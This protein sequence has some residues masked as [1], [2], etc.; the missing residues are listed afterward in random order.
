M[1]EVPKQF[2][3]YEPYRRFYGTLQQIVQLCPS[4]SVQ[5]LYYRCRWRVSFKS[6]TS[7]TLREGISGDA[8]YA[9]LNGDHVVDSNEQMCDRLC[10][11]PGICIR[12][13]Y[14]FQLENFD[15]S[16]QWVG[17]ER[18]QNVRNRIPYP[19]YQ[20]RKRGLLTYFYDGCWTGGEPIGCC[21]SACIGNFGKLEFEPLY[22]LAGRCFLSPPEK[23]EPQ[24][25][26][27]R[28]KFLKKLGLTSLGFNFSGYNLLTFSPLKYLDPESN[29]LT[30]M[31]SIR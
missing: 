15:L 10:H 27:H 12:H 9:D 16:M 8:M 3:L 11:P 28:K 7:A 17:S 5:R 29:P 25:H 31:E 18:Q 1:D 2:S 26:A 19:V 14:G 22:S 13:G 4:L 23:S 21:L 24:L 20:C 6:G 30:T